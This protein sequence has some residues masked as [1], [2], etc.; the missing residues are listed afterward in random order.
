MMRRVFLAL[1]LLALPARAHPLLQDAMWLVFSPER[2]R[3]AVNVSLKEITVAQAVLAAADGGYEAE[4]LAAAA[5]RH[6]AYLM[7]HLE[8]RAG[9]RM[10]A[11]TV[12]KVLPPAMFTSAEKTFYQYEM[13]YPL[14]GVRPGVVS[15][16]HEM[17]REFPYAAGMAWDV[18]Y[19][20]RMKRDGSPDISIGLLRA[21]SA[22]EFAT[23]WDAPAPTPPAR[24]NLP[25]RSLVLV[26]VSVCGAYLFRAA[27]RKQPNATK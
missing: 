25:M 12:V 15:L 5:E 22:A 14:D 7:K 18:S 11:G 17:L 6:R 27:L 9:G 4:E 19:V 8:V 24:G 23:G 16:R 2:V 26:A 1:F 3:V 20:V 10:L 21:G 13:E